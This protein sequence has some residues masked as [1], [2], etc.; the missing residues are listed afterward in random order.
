MKFLLEIILQIFD[1]SSSPYMSH[2][3]VWKLFLSVQ[4]PLNKQNKNKISKMKSVQ[5][6]GKIGFFIL[7]LWTSVKTQSCKQWCQIEEEI[8]IDGWLFLGHESQQLRSR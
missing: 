8:K 7:L 1:I 3:F 5:N 6:V 2:F 4:L